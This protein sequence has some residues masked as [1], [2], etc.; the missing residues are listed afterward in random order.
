M[1]VAAK[2]DIYC[3]K[4]LSAEPCKRAL[5]IQYF[6]FCEICK[7][8]TK[9]NPPEHTGECLVLLQ[10][11]NNVQ[12]ELTRSFPQ[13]LQSFVKSRAINFCR[14]LQ[15]RFCPCKHPHPAFFLL[16]FF[17]FFILGPCKS[18]VAGAKCTFASVALQVYVGSR[19]HAFC[20]DK[21][22]QQCLE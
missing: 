21:T 10:L 22:L 17:I 15:S 3:C 9:I 2:C 11:P 13:V 1:L 4:S 18:E 7:N 6:Y 19:R 16:L 8:Q 14:A 20:S 12:Q 5:C